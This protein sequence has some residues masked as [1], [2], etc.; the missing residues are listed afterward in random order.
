MT[1]TSKETAAKYGR[2]VLEKLMIEQVLELADKLVESGKAEWRFNPDNTNQ[3]DLVST[4][5]E[6]EDRTPQC[7][8]I[9]VTDVNTVDVDVELSYE[10]EELLIDEVGEFSEL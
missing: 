7:V 5:M 9:E 1:D 3:V 2:D 4:D 10:F 6:F 8:W